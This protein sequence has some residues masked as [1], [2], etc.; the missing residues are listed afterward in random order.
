MARKAMI[1]RT[2]KGTKVTA[3]MVDTITPRTYEQSFSI[4]HTYKDDKSLLKAV[5]A[6]ANDEVN[7]V[8][9]I[10]SADVFTTLYG[11]S[12]QKFIE[13]AEILPPRNA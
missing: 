7:R 11:M 6:V 9:R 13:N 1:T 4:A 8:V 12:E 2:I 3:L 10:L 5:E